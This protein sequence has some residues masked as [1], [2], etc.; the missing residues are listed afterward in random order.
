M[1][2]DLMAIFLVALFSIVVDTGDANG[3]TARSKMVLQK[4]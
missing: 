1:N 4:L 3:V 2:A